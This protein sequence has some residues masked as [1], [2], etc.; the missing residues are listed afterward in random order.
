MTIPVK[1][2]A[3]GPSELTRIW[4]G[5]GRKEMRLLEESLTYSN[6]PTGVREVEVNDD[7][8]IRC[9]VTY[10]LRVIEI[11][12]FPSGDGRERYSVV[13]P[14]NCN[15][16]LGF[17]RDVLPDQLEGATLY[18]VLACTQKDRYVLRRNILASDFTPYTRGQKVMLV[19]YLRMNYL[20]CSGST[21]GASGCRPIVDRREDIS[22]E[23]WR[24]TYRI[25]PWCASPVPKIIF[26][27]KQADPAR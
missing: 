1:I 26:V 24:T 7:V 22:E 12:A 4:T 19:P 9:T 10:G 2:V 8:F 25:V 23:A 13:C 15:F 6:L 14:C 3:Y 27:K 18:N 11:R 16:S 5:R 21:D 17:V 20:C